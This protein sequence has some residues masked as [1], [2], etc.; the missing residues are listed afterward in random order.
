MESP[1]VFVG[2]ALA[3]LN[4]CFIVTSTMN[5]PSAVYDVTGD[6][7][8]K[9]GQYRQWAGAVLPLG[10]RVFEVDFHVAKFRRIQEKYAGKV[11]VNWFHDDDLIT[12]ASLDP[13]LTVDDLIK[14]FELTP[15]PGYIE[16]ATRAQDAKRP[17]AAAGPSK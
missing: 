9:T 7:I 6:V 14:E 11:Q 3:W 4:Q 13:D 17:A 12:L 5:R 16:R 2:L 10:K 8:E 1:P 15:H